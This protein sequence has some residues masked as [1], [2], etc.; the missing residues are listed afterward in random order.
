[1]LPGI[2]GAVYQVHPPSSK[3]VRNPHLEQRLPRGPPNFGDAIPKS[4][5]VRSRRLQENA[6][7]WHSPGDVLRVVG[8]A[9]TDGHNHNPPPAPYLSFITQ[10][11]SQSAGGGFAAR[12]WQRSI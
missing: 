1:M 2:P 9:K 4:T 10:T 8:C 5:A 11:A 12:M 3:P 6:K 7:P